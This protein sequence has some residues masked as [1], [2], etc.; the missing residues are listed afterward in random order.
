MYYLN[1]LKDFVFI[2]CYVLGVLGGFGYSVYIK[3]GWVIPV[4]ILVLA[5]MAWPEFKKA[6][7]DITDSEKKEDAPVNTAGNKKKE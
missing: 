3:I 4:S 6:I 1:K 7:K 5:V 2:C